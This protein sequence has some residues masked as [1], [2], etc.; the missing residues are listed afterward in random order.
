MIAPTEPGTS[1]DAVIERLQSLGGVEV[2]RTLAATHAACPPVVVARMTKEKA[3]VLRRSADGKL[4][5]EPD[6]ALRAA[7]AAASSL[8]RSSIVTTPSGRG[9]AATIQVLGANDEPVEQAEVQ[10]IGQQWT[11]QGLTGSD[12]KVVLNLYGEMPD[13][14]RDILVRPRAD[15]WGL[16]KRHPKLQTEGV[17]IVALQPLPEL[18]R[19]GWG[20]RAMRLDQLPTEC[21]GGGVKIALLD[22]GVATSNAQLSAIAYGF[23]A[24]GDDEE[25]WSDDSTGHGTACAGVMFATDVAECIGGYAPD[26]ELHVCKL[27]ADGHCIDLVAALDYCI[28]A[29]VDLA[30]I[31]FGCRRGSAIVEQ[32]IV[33]A[34]R[35]GIAVIAAA[36][37]SGESVLFP[38]CSRH[39]LAVA[40]VGQMG[41]FPDETPHAVRAAVRAGTALRAGLFVPNFSCRGPELDLAAPGVAVIS[42]QSPEG[43]VAGD[44]TSLA[45]AHVAALAA[46][47]LAHGADFQREFVH[48]DARKAERLF[49]ILKATAQTIGDPAESGAG[50]PDALRALGL[51]SQVEASSP[52]LAAG[53]HDMHNALWLAGLKGA[54]GGAVPEPPRGPAAVTRIPLTLGPP[55]MQAAGGM[56]AGVNA[57]KAAMQLAGLSA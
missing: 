8:L 33:A 38:A 29:G 5:V 52:P 15:Y 10:L 1:Q 24:D 30:C 25:S 40:A 2:V 42:C 36:G 13:G 22:S 46:L 49:Q 41:T 32:R 20:A 31:G 26:A 37:S 54:N 34:K 21:R 28:Q 12:G 53:L 11:A 57:L 18:E 6:Q 48:R 45:A 55:S 7:S 23:E 16:W 50:L 17:N 56:K 39:V 19:F 51:R 47:V 44:G 3:A 43:Y 4:V 9:F 27:P 14:V 35:R